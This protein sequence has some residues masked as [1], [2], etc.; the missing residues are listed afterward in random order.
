MPAAP[1]IV[2]RPGK[3]FPL[4]RTALAPAYELR[5]EVGTPTDVSPPPFA[6]V[7]P[8][9]E[10]PTPW[11]GEFALKPAANEAWIAGEPARVGPPSHEQSAAL[12][13]SE[14]HSD[15]IEVTES[16][17]SGE[18]ELTTEERDLMPKFFS[19]GGNDFDSAGS[20]LG[21]RSPSQADGF[22]ASVTP[23]L[24][25]VSPVSTSR[26]TAE[27]LHAIQR[28]SRFPP[29]AGKRAVEIVVLGSVIAVAAFAIIACVITLL[30]AA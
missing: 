4:V 25:L 5:E 16:A 8:D 2:P 15:V 30:R 1:R 7:F 18:R 6:D 19:F 3:N 23:P 20:M 24:P 21:E 28:M 10:P 22:R 12:A 13:Q 26:L 17:E 11:V 29:G 27:D 14:R 9:D